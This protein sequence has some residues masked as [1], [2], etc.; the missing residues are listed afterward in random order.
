MRFERSLMELRASE[1]SF[2]NEFAASNE[3]DPYEIACSRTSSVPPL[4]RF[5]KYSLPS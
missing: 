1:D 4:R 3:C 5:P 2:R